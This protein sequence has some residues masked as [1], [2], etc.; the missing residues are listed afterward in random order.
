MA[1]GIYNLEQD[2]LCIVHLLLDRGAD[3]NACDDGNAT[4]LNWASF[5]G[6]VAIARV[7][8]D[9]GAA[10]G[11][12]GYQGRTPLHSAAEGTSGS[13]HPSSEGDGIS[14]GIAQLLM[15]HGADANAQDDDDLTPLHLA[16]YYGTVEIARV[17]LDGGARPN[18]KSIRGRTPLHAVAEGGDY[19]SRDNDI[20]VTR[21]LLERG[22]EVNVPD[23]E[24][25]TPLHLASYFGKVE[26]ILELLNVNADTNAKNT[27]GQIP[28]DLA[29]ENP[30]L[31]VN[32]TML[33]SWLLRGT[34]R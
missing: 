18:S 13:R 28:F 31:D 29:L 33:L 4:P 16:S 8:L 7:L 2:R 27:Q 24:N 26:M 9:H 30:Q 17:L 19:Y 20:L 21:L 10:V 34:S 11:S 6:K 32:A 12:K 15:E 22:A 5:G 23:G 14:T 3:V 1:G 25:Q